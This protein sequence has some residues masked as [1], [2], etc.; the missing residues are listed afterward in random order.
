MLLL[1]KEKASS[2][3]LAQHLIDALVNLPAKGKIMPARGVGITFCI[4]FSGVQKSAEHAQS[5]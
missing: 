3:N 1:L 4:V 2:F 5:L